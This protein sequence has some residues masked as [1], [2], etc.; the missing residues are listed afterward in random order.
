VIN[1][2]FAVPPAS[3]SQGNIKNGHAQYF[4]RNHYFNF[5]VAA[6]PFRRVTIFAS[7]RV[8]KDLGQ[9]DRQSNFPAGLFISSYPYSYQ[10]PEARVSLRLNRRVDANFGYQYF[11]YNESELLR[12]TQG[13]YFVVPAPQNY[14]A[15]LPYVSLRFYFGHAER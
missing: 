4:L 13:S 11:N 6:Q 2:T 9:G 12:Q 3:A 5:D 10:S 8:N 7:Y 1:Y 15:H 14:N